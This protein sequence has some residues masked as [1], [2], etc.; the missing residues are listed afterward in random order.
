MS[1]PQ[2]NTI[3][4]TLGGSA[5]VTSV[6]SSGKRPLP[7]VLGSLVIAGAVGAI[8]A[9]I[10]TSPPE[11]RGTQIDYKWIGSAPSSADTAA[12]GGEDG[13][14]AMSA[15]DAAAPSPDDA[16]PS[17]DATAGT[18]AAPG[19]AADLESEC[20]GFQVDRKWSELVQCADKLKATDPKR[21]EELRAQAAQGIETARIASFEAALRSNNLKAAQAELERV[22]PE[23]VEYPRLK[24]R[25]AAAVEGQ[26]TAN[27][28]ARL[29]HALSPS[30]TEY[31]AILA[32]ERTS[33]PERI[34][35]SATRQVTCTPLS[36]TQCDAKALAERG[37]QLHAAGKLVLAIAS[38]ESSWI[39][40]RD[41][42]TAQRGFIIA[43]S[44]PDLPKAKVYWRR[45]PMETKKSAVAFCE[46]NKITEQ[47]LNAR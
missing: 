13:K 38:Y 14:L 23:S 39:C 5:G 18:T 11:S 1:I 29:A 47:Q 35:T 20:R 9:V 31:S 42:Q 6:L 2:L 8:A 34:I 3:D 25:Y 33:Q 15:P 44:I 45:L 28:V 24:Q 41:P 17:P 36:P 7:Y 21:A 30:C 43:C 32:K 37:R 16:A 46:N 12:A 22:G 4:T 27:L 40:K 10:S 19:A 26:V